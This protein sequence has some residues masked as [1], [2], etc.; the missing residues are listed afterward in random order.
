VPDSALLVE[1]IERRACFLPLAALPV[2]PRSMRPRLVRGREL[3]ALCLT[4]LP[5]HLA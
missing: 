2:R 4:E 3:P 1:I 5:R